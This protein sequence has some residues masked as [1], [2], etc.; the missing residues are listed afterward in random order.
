MAIVSLGGLLYLLPPLCCGLFFALRVIQLHVAKHNRRKAVL[1]ELKAT[2]PERKRLIGFFHP[3][4]NAGGGGE[5]VL[6]TAIAMLQ[7]SEPDVVNVVYTGDIDVTKAQ[8]IERVKARFDIELAPSSLHFVFLHSRYLVED[9]TWR[10]FTLLGQS[11][12]SMYLAWEAMS[13]LVPDLYIDTMGYAFTF[14]VVR[15]LALTKVGAYV[16]YPTISTDMLERVRSRRAW[17]TNSGAIASSA[18]LSKAKLFHDLSCGSSHYSLLNRAA[19][20]HMLRTFEIRS[21]ELLHLI[22]GTWSYLRTS[23]WKHSKYRRTR[24]IRAEGVVLNSHQ[25]PAQSNNTYPDG[26]LFVHSL[27]KGSTEVHQPHLT[28]IGKSKRTPE[29]ASIS[30]LVLST[31]RGAECRY[32]AAKSPFAICRRR[33]PRDSFSIARSWSVPYYGLCCGFGLRLG[34]RHEIANYGH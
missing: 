29:F 5:R 18:V 31:P 21:V 13:K 17:H 23:V 34:C 20:V 33:C 22:T 1:D 8:I 6:W 4:C 3:Y 28:E 2:D 27:P 12:G 10:R 16:H 14:P 19:S 11:I 26:V 32:N 30:K 15:W 9:T 24:P 7:R 25:L